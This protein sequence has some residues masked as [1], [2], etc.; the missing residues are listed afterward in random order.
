MKSRVFQNTIFVLQEKFDLSIC[1]SQID[2]ANNTVS[3]VTKKIKDMGSED[4]NF[5]PNF[6]CFGIDVANDLQ[7]LDHTRYETG[8]L[9]HMSLL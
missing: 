9:G 4:V 1:E 8:S 6:Q 2:P 5:D 7:F 3:Q